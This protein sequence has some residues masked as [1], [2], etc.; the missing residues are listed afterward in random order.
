M[1]PLI[2]AASIVALAQPAF[3][4]EWSDWEKKHSVARVRDWLVIKKPGEGHCYIKQSYKDDPSKLELTMGRT[5]GPAILTPFF[6]GF[7]GEV[8]YRVDKRKPGVIPASSIDHINLI[9]LPREVIPA[10]RAGR[11]L[12]IRLTPIG[13]PPRDQTFSLMGFSAA[14]RWLKRSVCRERASK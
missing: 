1:R 9:E 10:F 6:R 7:E 8:T 11:K 4:V 5:G 14:S 2:L 13:E 12:R 3:A